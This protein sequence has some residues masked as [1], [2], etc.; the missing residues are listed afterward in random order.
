MIDFRLISS[1][2][3]SVK[4]FILSRSVIVS[5]YFTI[6]PEVAFLSAKMS[7]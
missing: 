2:R 3:R 6:V 7:F 4:A 1:T 5:V